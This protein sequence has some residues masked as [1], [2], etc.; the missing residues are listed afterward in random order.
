[1]AQAQTHIGE[2]K[3]REARGELIEVIQR[4]PENKEAGQLF[5]RL[6]TVLEMSDEQ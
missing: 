5:K 4:D 6:Q 2:K 3:Y 1:M